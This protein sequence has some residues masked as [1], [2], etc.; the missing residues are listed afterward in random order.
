MKVDR[1][2]HDPDKEWEFWCNHCEAGFDDADAD[3]AVC[4]QCGSVNGVHRASESAWAGSGKRR[5]A[6]ITVESSDYDKAA[7]ILRLRLRLTKDMKYTAMGF[8]FKE[9]DNE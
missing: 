8:E 9:K 2:E 7:G 1:M 6:E 5:R 4:P 3:F